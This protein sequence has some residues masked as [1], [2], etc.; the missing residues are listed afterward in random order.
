V[1]AKGMV[2]QLAQHLL[3]PWLLQKV[4][5]RGEGQRVGGGRRECNTKRIPGVRKKSGETEKT[6]DPRRQTLLSSD[7]L[8]KREDP[9]VRTS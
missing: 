8:Q 6:Q 3:Q 2:V 7:A 1:K 4:Q 9:G 5:E